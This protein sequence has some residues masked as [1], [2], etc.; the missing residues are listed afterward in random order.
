MLGEGASAFQTH[1]DDNE[2]EPSKDETLCDVHPEKKFDLFCVKCDILICMD[3]KLSEHLHHESQ[4]LAEATERA[5]AQLAKDKARLQEAK[6]DVEK[7]AAHWTTDQ[8]E[9][10]EKKAVVEREI[11]QRHSTLVAAADKYR[12]EALEALEAAF[13]EKQNSRAKDLTDIHNNTDE[14]RKLQELID[15]AETRR[16]G[17][18]I[19]TVAKKMKSGSGS[20]AAVKQLMSIPHL[21]E[22]IRPV[23]RSVVPKDKSTMFD[24]MKN[25]IGVSEL[26]QIKFAEAEVKAEEQFRSD[27]H[28]DITVFFVYCKAGRNVIVSFDPL[29]SQQK[30]PVKRYSEPGVF[31]REEIL[32]KGKALVG[33]VSMQE[34]NETTVFSEQDHENIA[35]KSPS[36]LIFSISSSGTNSQIRTN[37][38]VSR[39]P[40]QTKET[41]LFSINC[42]YHRGFDVHSSQDLLAVVT[43]TKPP[44]TDRKVLLFKRPKINLCCWTVDVVDTYTSPLTAFRPADVCFFTLRGQEVHVAVYFCCV[45]FSY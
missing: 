9:F 37:K 8:Q 6:A 29:Y 26:V 15:E 42:D 4:T 14:L 17:C 23:H 13:N 40:F 43:E 19:V 5:T 12:D 30:P 27:D 10:K 11:R 33:K 22:V 18:K 35:K 32:S 28:D 38:V 39:N 20:P 31:I 2:P 34:K 16:E 36:S 7:N 24:S 21:T 44:A 3:C 45:L 1:T 41:N 25:F